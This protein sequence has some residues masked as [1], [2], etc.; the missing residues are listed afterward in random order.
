MSI[1]T[2]IDT[3]IEEINIYDNTP[4]TS[5]GRRALTGA[6][7]KGIIGAGIGR[8]LHPQ[9]AI[10]GAA[11]GAGGGAIDHLARESWS[12]YRAR[13]DNKYGNPNRYR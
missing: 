11:I 7:S 12:R 9:G 1:F 2:N 3:L 6:V 8:V 4:G 13:R 10:A 5:Y